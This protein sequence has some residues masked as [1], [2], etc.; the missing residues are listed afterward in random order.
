MRA[1][2]KP[3]GQSCYTM[4]RYGDGHHLLGTASSQEAAIIA[5]ILRLFNSN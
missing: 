1:S 3:V 5:T 4:A 2:C